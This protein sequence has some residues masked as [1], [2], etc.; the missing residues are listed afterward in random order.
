MKN[1]NLLF[2]FGNNLAGLLCSSH[3]SQVLLR[4]HLQD[5]LSMSQI[6]SLSDFPS[7]FLSIFFKGGT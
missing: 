6:Y 4:E 2:L 7:L 3:W 1:I 5:V